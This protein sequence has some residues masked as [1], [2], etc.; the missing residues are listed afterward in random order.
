[1]TEEYIQGLR[2]QLEGFSQDEQQ[3]FLEEIRSHIESGEEDPK[4]GKN[5]E[6]RRLKLMSELGSAKDLSRNFKTTYRQNSLFDYLWIAIPYFLYPYLNMLYMGLMSKFSWADVRLDIL[7][8]LPL[9]AVGLWRRSGTVTMFWLGT[10][11]TQIGT[12]LLVVHGYYGP[13]QTVFWILFMVGLIALLGYVVWQNRRDT[14]LVV[15][16]LLPLAMCLVGSLAAIVHPG[17]V[18]AYGPVDQV[19]LRIYTE[20]AGLGSG[21]L[22]YYGTLIALALFLLATNRGLRW[23]ALGLYGLVIGLSR[24]FINLFDAETGLMLQWVYVL[25]AVLPLVIV[26]LGWWLDPSRTERFQFAE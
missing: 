10:V 16:A 13:A 18:A 19:L 25:F 23:L 11:I 1:M 21:Y 2:K 26:F 9:V 5:L 15:F 22:P 12:M 8:H 6:Q 3:A 14:L 4:M 7:I 24:S 20:I 17:A